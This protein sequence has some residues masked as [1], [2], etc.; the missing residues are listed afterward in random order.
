LEKRYDFLN[1][2]SGKKIQ[3]PFDQLIIFSTNLEPKDLVDGAFLRRIP[4]KI[5]APDPTEEQFRALMELMAPM[6]GF[7]YDSE[8]KKAVD[9]LIETHY[10]AVDRPFRACQPRDLLLQV[11]NHCVYHKQ[12]K[13]LTNKGFDFAV[14]NYFS[15][16]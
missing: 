5:E 11:K 13:K 3:V 4:Y 16:M 7:A 8:A 10:K 9:Y 6:M 15:V 2:P 14:W 1:L 12:P